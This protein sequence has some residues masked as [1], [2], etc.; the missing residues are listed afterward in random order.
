MA[1]LSLPAVQVRADEVIGPGRAIVVVAISTDATLDVRSALLDSHTGR[2]VTLGLT[3]GP[4]PSLLKGPRDAMAAAIAIRNWV[5]RNVGDVEID[6]VLAAPAPF[7]LFLGHV[8]DRI[9]P[10]TI[11]EDLVSGYESAFRVSN[12]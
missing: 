11:Y 9:V 2:L 7:A 8:W 4:S 1:G 12:Y 3:E 6:L 10:T 5:R